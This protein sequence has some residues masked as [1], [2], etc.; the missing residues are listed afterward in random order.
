MIRLCNL[1]N[2]PWFDIISL[3]IALPLEFLS[4]KSQAIESSVIW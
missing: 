3:L 1:K 4:K 2:G